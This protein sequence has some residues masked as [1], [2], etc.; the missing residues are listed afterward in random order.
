MLPLALQVQKATGLTIGRGRYG[1]PT[2]EFR[3][4]AVQNDAST[5]V[6]EVVSVTTDVAYDNAGAGAAVA[7]AGAAPGASADA[8][9]AAVMTTTVGTSSEASSEQE[10]TRVTLE[11]DR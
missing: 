9:S 4:W 6:A 5:V 8:R 7:R 11:A 3:R 1:Q 2:L 10:L